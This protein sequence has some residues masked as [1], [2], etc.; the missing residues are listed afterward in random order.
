MTIHIVKVYR[1]V[2]YDQETTVEVEG[3]NLNIE[4]IKSKT[5]DEIDLSGEWDEDC[6]NCCYE[7]EYEIDG[8]LYDDNGNIVN[9][10]DWITK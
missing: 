4:Q 5:I 9:M 3:D 2:S 1:K 6:L 8:K 7:D 10:L